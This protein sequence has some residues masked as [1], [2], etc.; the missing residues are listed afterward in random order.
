MPQRKYKCFAEIENGSDEI[1]VVLFQ[2]VVFVTRLPFINLMS[3]LMDIVAPEFFDNGEPCLEAGNCFEG[4]KRTRP[5]NRLLRFS[6]V[7]SRFIHT[8]AAETNVHF[9]LVMTLTSG[10]L[11]CLEKHS[12]CR[13]WGQCC[14]SEYPVERTN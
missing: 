8:Q 4:A 5:H 2:S 3:E 9:Q 12:T 10:R 1:C 11:P 14:K 6:A 7:E 13:S